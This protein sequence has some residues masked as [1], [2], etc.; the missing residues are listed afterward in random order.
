MSGLIRNA[1]TNNWIRKA[2]VR[3]IIIHGVLKR[4]ETSR[5]AI[6]NTSR[7]E[8]GPD[9]TGLLLLK[10]STCVIEEDIF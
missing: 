3:E 1:N 4:T 7:D 2:S 10:C 9:W 5:N 6:C 8:K